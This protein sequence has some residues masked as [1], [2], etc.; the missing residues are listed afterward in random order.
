MARKK[1]PDILGIALEGQGPSDKK[2]ID[3]KAAKTEEAKKAGIDQVTKNFVKKQI[4]EMVA[5]AINAVTEQKGEMEKIKSHLDALKTQMSKL[6]QETADESAE[7]PPDYNSEIQALAARIKAL[8]LRKDE[9]RPAENIELPEEESETEA[10]SITEVEI[11][12]KPI[13]EVTEE[14]QPVTEIE[15]E[16]VEAVSEVIEP[17]PEPEPPKPPDPYRTAI[18]KTIEKMRDRDG[19]SYEDISKRLENGGLKPIPNVD[20]W[21]KETVKLLIEQGI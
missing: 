2:D 4:K 8:E 17:E 7:E 11:A 12:E 20:K 1:T 19:L 10:E 14:T 5:E 6:Q 9:I 15:E 16:P 21:D 3:G 18:I 13:E